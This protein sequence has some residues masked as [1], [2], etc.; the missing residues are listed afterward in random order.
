MFRRCRFTILHFRLWIYCITNAFC[1][2]KI[3][4]VFPSLPLSILTIYSLFA[5][6]TTTTF[7]PPGSHIE[8]NRKWV[9]VGIHGKMKG[10][11]DAEERILNVSSLF[12][13][14]YSIRRT[15]C[16]LNVLV[17]VSRFGVLFNASFVLWGS[18]VDGV[19]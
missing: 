6:Q 11:D 15:F 5:F 18:C 4:V 7:F 9:A 13:W 16:C 2:R 14:I 12:N 1:M 17:M 10:V 3:Y 19:V 8:T